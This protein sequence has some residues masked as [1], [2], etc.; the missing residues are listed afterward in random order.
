MT[1]TPLSGVPIIDAFLNVVGAGIDMVAASDRTAAIRQTAQ[2]Q[3]AAVD[4]T[5]LYAGQVATAQA[6][7]QAPIDEAQ[8]KAATQNLV[9]IAGVSAAILGALFLSSRIKK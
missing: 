9:R 3:Q 4:Y 6:E 8:K 5:A 2:E 1:Y 7:R